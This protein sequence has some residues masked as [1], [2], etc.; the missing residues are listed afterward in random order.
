MCSLVV[1]H[2]VGGRGRLRAGGGDGERLGRV[3]GRVVGLRA[4]AAPAL[5]RA[6]APAPRAG[7]GA[8]TTPRAPA[9]YRQQGKELFNYLQF[10]VSLLSLQFYI[11]ISYFGKKG[12][13]SAKDISN[14]H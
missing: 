14:R 13:R 9:A 3:L 11:R 8:G 2:D 6:A 10:T 5:A 4:G 12:V 1:G 7:A